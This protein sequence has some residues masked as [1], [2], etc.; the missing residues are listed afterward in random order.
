MNTLIMFIFY[1]FYLEYEAM[2]SYVAQSEDELG[3]SV[4]ERVTVLHKSLDGWWKI[5]CP[6]K[7]NTS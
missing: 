3:L 5:R 4:G 2:E 1:E 7:K 6:F